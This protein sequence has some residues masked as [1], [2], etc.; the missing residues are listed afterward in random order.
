M[1]IHEPSPEFLTSQKLNIG[2]FPFY[3]TSVLLL[4][5]EAATILVESSTWIKTLKYTRLPVNCIGV[6]LKCPW[7]ILSA[8]SNHVCSAVLP[9]IYLC[10]QSTRF[11]RLFKFNHV[12]KTVCH[13][14][15]PHSITCI[16]CPAGFRWNIVE[17]LY[18]QVH[19]PAYLRCLND[20]EA[21]SI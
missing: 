20:D 10:G 14:H 13:L 18:L 17:K 4:H 2:A 6:R 9:P 7:I 19:S 21:D 12:Y 11:N 1:N 16:F 3:T 15:T 5:G 8:C